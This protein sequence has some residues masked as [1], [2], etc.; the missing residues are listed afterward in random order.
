VSSRG[1]YRAIHTVLI[2]GAD[3][4]ALSPT[5]KL[6][7]LTI[8]LQLGP[9]GIDV[10]YPAV[11]EEQ[12]G[13]SSDQVML[14]LT[15]LEHAGW[16]QRER[17]VVWIVGG[18]KHDPHFNTKLPKHKQGLANHV[19]GLPRLRIVQR[20]IAAYPNH[21]PPELAPV[22][23]VS[24]SHAEGTGMVSESH[25]DGIGMVSESGK[26]KGKR[27]RKEGKGVLRR[28]DRGDPP[29]ETWVQR[30]TAEWQSLV[31]TIS[32]GQVGT[33]KPYID[34][35]GE[36]VVGSAMRLYVSHQKGAGRPPRFGW[37]VESCALWCER[38]I[39]LRDSPLDGDGWMSA[40][41]ELATRPGAA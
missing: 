23:E 17:N 25:S 30:L 33:A 4:Q 6:V 18:L 37:F 34:E 26:G 19:A 10:L 9:S 29:P 31:G 20:F 38:A 39:A 28:D 22:V 15:T 27:E 14:A 24:E 35:H 7:F 12:T 40:E 1:E 11:L 8:K 3:Y 32:H 36:S 13:L 5:A 41:L 21:F 2:D 16:I